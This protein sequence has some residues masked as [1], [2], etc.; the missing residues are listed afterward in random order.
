M[1]FK[2]HLISPRQI[3]RRGPFSYCP[4]ALDLESDDILEKLTEE[5]AD[6][7]DYMGSVGWIFE[8]LSM[9]F[10][11]SIIAFYADRTEE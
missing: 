9:S 7:W 8:V 5:I 4:E 1:C 6:F 11:S 10:A 3:F 2:H